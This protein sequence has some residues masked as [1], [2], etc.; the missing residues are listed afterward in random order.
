M[1]L[2][3]DTSVDGD[4]AAAITLDHQLQFAAA[5]TATAIAQRGQQ[6]A[7]AE[8]QESFTTRSPWYLP[9]NLYGVH[10]TPAT[11]NRPT[12][13]VHT[14]AYWLVPHEQGG[15]KTPSEGDFLTIP[16]EAIQPDRTAIIPASNRPKNRPDAFVVNTKR[17]PKLFERING[18]LQAIYHL[19]R[20]VRVEKR[21]TIVDPTIRVVENEFAPTFHKKLEEAIKTAK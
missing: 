18:A 2:E 5:S 3:I 10:Y 1:S 13:Q 20:S 21:S 8:I 4:L 19:V 16:T 11:P 7:I 14:N 6:E 9:T 12:S 17:G 15:L